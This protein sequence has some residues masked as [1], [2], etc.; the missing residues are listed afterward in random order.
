MNQKEKISG[1]GKL[2]TRQCN[3]LEL[4]Q[5]GARIAKPGPKYKF[6]L[7]DDKRNPLSYVHGRTFNS[8]YKKQLLIK[9]SD[10]SFTCTRN[11]K[12]RLSKQ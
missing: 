2:T 7:L 3:V 4:L 9:K 5:A 8:L 11:I 10:G 12:R 1:G 6:R